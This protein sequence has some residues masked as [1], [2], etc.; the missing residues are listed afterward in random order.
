MSPDEGSC[1]P[2]RTLSKVCHLQ[3]RNP[4]WVFSCQTRILPL[5][6]Q[7]LG[8]MLMEVS[9]QGSH[10]KKACYCVSNLLSS[11]RARPDL[12][13]HCPSFPY[14]IHL[15]VLNPHFV[16]LY[17]RRMTL[18]VSIRGFVVNRRHMLNGIV[19]Y[20]SPLLHISLALSPSLIHII[21]STEMTQTVLSFFSACKSPTQSQRQ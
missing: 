16:S 12:S 18:A 3:A 20:I 5:N 11:E 19:G 13:W 7:C 10:F 8:K 2:Y 17:N 9:L 21:H 4:A 14:S 15:F 6:H 1:Y